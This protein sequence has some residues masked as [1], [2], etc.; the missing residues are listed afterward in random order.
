ME[1]NEL[2]N[3]VKAIRLSRNEIEFLTQQAQHRDQR[4]TTGLSETLH[5]L[6]DQARETGQGTMTAQ[7]EIGK[8][9]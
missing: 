8:L 1:K 6:I 3:I 2:H 5:K 4:A 9:I 7:N